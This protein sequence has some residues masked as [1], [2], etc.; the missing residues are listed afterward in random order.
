MY[1]TSQKIKRCCKQFAITYIDFLT[2]CWFSWSALA[3]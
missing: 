2:F 3:D 1:C